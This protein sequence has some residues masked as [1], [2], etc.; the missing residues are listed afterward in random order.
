MAQDQ[1]VPPNSKSAWALGLCLPS[2]PWLKTC[3]FLALGPTGLWLWEQLIPD[4]CV[5][6]SQISRP[7]GSWLW[8]WPVPGSV[9]NW[10]LTTGPTV[11]WL[12]DQLVP[13]C[14]LWRGYHI[15]QRRWHNIFCLRYKTAQNEYKFWVYLE[16]SW[17]KWG[18]WGHGALEA[19]ENWMMKHKT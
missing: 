3:W 1:L 10:S 18:G 11:A 15:F 5:N 12:E 14:S 4:S 7:T 8:D 17:Q 19:C 16:L 6:S 9:T 2:G 13:D